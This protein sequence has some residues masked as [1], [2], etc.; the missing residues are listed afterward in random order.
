VASPTT[1]LDHIDLE[2]CEKRGIKVVSLNGE[3]RFLDTVTSTAEHTVGLMIALLRNY[4]QSLNYP[5][6]ERDYYTGHRVSGQTLGIIGYG[7]IGQQV[8]QIA[9]SLGM[10]VLYGEL[11]SVLMNSDIV[12]LHIP[13]EN[14][15]GF[16]TKQMFRNMKPNSYLINTSRS[17]IIEDGALLWALENGTIK[18]AAQDFIDD[19]E[20]L[21]YSRTHDNL[22]LT[23]H[24][25]GNTFEDRQATEDFINKKIKNGI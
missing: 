5:Y 16:F 13:L 22:I 25:G 6:K 1:G 23:N 14:N 2:E 20:L 18:G 19:L 17:K 15:K 3:R 10:R 12:S 24:Q 8:E 11:T 7:R 21:E 9:E 4:K